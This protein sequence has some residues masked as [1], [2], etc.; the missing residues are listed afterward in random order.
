MGS[1]LLDN[2]TILLFGGIA[3]STGFKSCNLMFKFDLKDES[4][5]L[6]ETLP[7]RSAFTSAKST[8]CQG[9]HYI[10]CDDFKSILEITKRGRTSVK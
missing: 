5:D 9:S 6:V 2:K 3:Q 4:V 8:E 7:I 10:L 1:L